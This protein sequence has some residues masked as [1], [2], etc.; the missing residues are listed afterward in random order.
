MKITVRF[1]GIAY[2]YTGLREWKPELEF[3]ANILDL[4]KN[5]VLEFPKLRDLVYDDTG[6][7]IEYLAVSINNVDILGLNGVNTLLS[8]GDVVFVMPPIGGG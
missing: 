6:D 2:D 4:M 7:Y 3:G 5:I 8:E 1:Y